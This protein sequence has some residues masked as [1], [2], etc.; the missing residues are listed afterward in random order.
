MQLVN[1]R[2]NG[3]ISKTTN[4]TNEQGKREELAGRERKLTMTEHPPFM[5]CAQTP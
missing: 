2:H 5:H 4:V 1:V 3:N